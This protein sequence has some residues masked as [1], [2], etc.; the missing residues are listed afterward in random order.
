M[1]HGDLERHCTNGYPVD[2]LNCRIVM[3]H[4]N[5]QGPQDSA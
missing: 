1:Q 4:C 5:N 2:Q 3:L